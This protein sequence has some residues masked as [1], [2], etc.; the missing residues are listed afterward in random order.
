MGKKSKWHS[1]GT[2][3]QGNRILRPRE[4]TMQPVRIYKPD[5]SGTLQLVDVVE[6]VFDLGVIPMRAGY[7]KKAS[8]TIICE[9]CKAKV[10]TQVTDKTTCKK[11]ACEMVIVDRKVATRKKMGLK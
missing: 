8:R 7:H 3:G 5:S 1:R 4:E 10:R 6:P 9:V 2:K 11:R